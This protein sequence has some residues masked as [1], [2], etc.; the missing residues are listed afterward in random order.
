M[1]NIIQ[2]EKIN[3]NTKNI[4]I[5]PSLEIAKMINDED[6]KVALAIENQLP[7][8]AK[9]IDLANDAFR[10]GGRMLY[11]GAGTSGRLGVLDASEI[12][13]TFNE[14]E[15]ICG[16]IAGGDRL[17]REPAECSED[18][19]EFGMQDLLVNAKATDKDVVVAIS[20][21]GGPVYLKVILEEARKIGAKTVAISC[22]SEA[23]IG[24]LSDIHIP[25]IVGPEVIA[26]SSRMKAGTSQK[27]VLNMISTG[28]M[29][30][31][32]KT[33]ENLMVDGDPSNLKLTD[34]AIRI[35]VDITNS[36][37]Q[38]A[39]EIL[40]AANYSVKKSVVMI[41]KNCDKKTATNLLKENDDILRK[42][43]D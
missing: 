11:F 35:I 32:G 28:A 37:Y 30:K 29:I 15:K 38:K 33:Y 12:Y 8:I 20:A 7:Q 16:F 41:V 42:V 27:M 14:S 22:N 10:N 31:Y 24:Q 19:A 5:S 6:K 43:I 34:R 18:D 1:N 2:T 17:L 25:V 4:D 23:K 13:P 26:G 9:V 39:E 40:K 21:S 3:S 36:T